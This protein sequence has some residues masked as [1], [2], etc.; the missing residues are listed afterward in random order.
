MFGI[1]AALIV[2]AVR[3]FCSSGDHHDGRVLSTGNG[4]EISDDSLQSNP[5]FKDGIRPRIVK[6]KELQSPFE[7]VTATVQSVGSD[8]CVLCHQAIADSYFGTGMGQ[9]L[10]LMTSDTEPPDAFIADP[11][12]FPRSYRVLRRDGVMW[13]Q[14]L[15]SK[16]PSG[17][18][19]ELP[20]GEDQEVILG[21]YPVKWQIG[22]GH[23]SRSYLIEI[24]GF[25]VES[26]VTWYV[27]RQSW[28]MSPGFDYPSHPGFGRVSD[29]SC[30]WCHVGDARPMDGSSHRLTIH[31]GAI[32]CER[33]H[34]AGQLHVQRRQVEGGNAAL[35]ATEFPEAAIDYSI[36][37][38]RHLDRELSDSICGQ[39]H[40]RSAATALVPG[41]RLDDFRPGL[42]LA[43]FRTDYRY[44][45]HQK[46]NS[47]S[48]RE[49]SS[50]DPNRPDLMTVV[51]H[52]EQLQLSGCYQDSRLS[53]VLC[54]N[55]HGGISPEERPRHY[56]SVCLQCHGSDECQVSE[57]ELQKRS[58]G[59][60][61]TICHMPR[62]GT[63]I[64]H[65]T[66]THHRIGH[67]LEQSSWQGN[68]TSSAENGR[69][70]TLVPLTDSAFIRP[71]LKEA[72]LGLAY[73]EFAGRTEGHSHSG[74]YLRRAYQLLVR[75]WQQGERSPETASALVA[76]GAGNEVPE[77]AKYVQAALERSN[78]TAAMRVNFLLSQ[79]FSLAD[80]KRYVAASRLMEKVVVIRRAPIDWQLLGDF[81]QAAGTPR[82]AADAFE[83]A[84]QI[85]PLNSD[86]RRWLIDYYHQMNEHAKADQHRKM[87]LLSR[88]R[89]ASD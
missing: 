66:F 10:V 35:S 88:S 20:I 80:Q 62:S 28:G 3:Q 45:R 77:L 27:S 69:A 37:N 1:A 85:S 11:A 46:T 71:P 57:S 6:L 13:H 78:I 25:L 24:D 34:G 79:A 16:D 33:C 22:S 32:G 51:G 55:P 43:D 40:L 14:E 7:N 29:A 81:R 75:A 36:V 50:T 87:L 42:N 64:P 56:R 9:S 48:L 26:P 4:S 30:L 70:G 18:D 23:H 2:I 61:C 17:T 19:E 58:A 39:C 73:L 60:D 59:N 89:A 76:L 68:P 31:D 74:E 5:P 86:V 63:D 47:S 54:H 72:M 41:R 82:Q 53:C 67:H 8:T 84:L 49:D 21:E 12:S 15:L 44:E 52:V 83:T 65:L 38:P